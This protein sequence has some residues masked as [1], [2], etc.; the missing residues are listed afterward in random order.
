MT[1]EGPSDPSRPPFSKHRY[2]YVALKIVVLLVA[3][4]LAARLFGV[5]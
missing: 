1:S 3:V 5:V 2:Y 4:A